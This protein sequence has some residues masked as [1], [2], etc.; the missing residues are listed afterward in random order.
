MALQKIRLQSGQN[1]SQSN[2]TLRGDSQNNATLEGASEERGSNSKRIL[3]SNA[4]ARVKR[5]QAMQRA[6]LQKIEVVSPK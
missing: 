6:W 5:S 2:A 3:E 1:T 4:V